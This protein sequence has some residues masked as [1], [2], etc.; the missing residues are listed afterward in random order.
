MARCCRSW[1]GS[2]ARS[3]PTRTISSPVQ[4][5]TY[6]AI[7]KQ[8]TKSPIV[9][10]GAGAG[11]GPVV[12]LFDK[13]GDL[14]SQQ[15]AFDPNFRNGVSVAT[16]DFDGDGVPDLAVANGPG[17]PPTVTL[18]D[19]ATGVVLKTMTVFEPNFL[20][21]VNVSAADFDGDGLA[22]L[23]VAPGPGGG[24]RVRILKVTDGSTVADFFGIADTA[25]RGGAEPRPVT[26]TATASST[27][28]SPPA[29]AADRESP[30]GTARP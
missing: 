10:V 24:P 16:A 22:E 5:A 19:G 30:A 27:S 3:R 14:Q 1:A 12:K 2:T 18:Y 25:F 6:L 23:I 7:Y 21:G 20:G 17:L 26:S 8:P 15:F 9:A 29:T 4:D 13:S 28:S 11:G